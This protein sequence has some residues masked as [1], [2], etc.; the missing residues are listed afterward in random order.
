LP[1]VQ[2]FFS[3]QELSDDE[4]VQLLSHL[5]E[6]QW[7]SILDLDLWTRDQVSVERFLK[8][9]QFIIQVEDPVARKILRGT[10]PTLWQLAFK[11]DLGLFAR[12][13][14]DEFETGSE[15]G[16]FLTPEGHYLVV[17]PEDVEKARLYRQLILRLYELDGSY[18]PYLFNQTRFATSVEL[19][20][21]AYQE[22]KL[23]VED[24][25][26]QDYFDAM[27]IYTERSLL[28][29]L[30]EKRWASERKDGISLLPTRLTG[31]EGGPLLLFQV[32]AAL[33]KEEEIQHLVEELFFVCNKLL[34]A[35]QLLPSAPA[36]IKE[37]IRK[38]ISGINL[39]LELWSD[40]QLER[41][42]SGVRQR[43]LVSF[44]QIGYGRLSLL[45]R[46][47]EALIGKAPL[48]SFLEAAVEGLCLQ[49][50]VLS[51]QVGGEIQHRY[52][53]TRYD[54]K[55]ARKI[56]EEVVAQDGSR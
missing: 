14:E 46:S 37:G 1:A 49:F 42:A 9:A 55:W 10:N 29:E 20:E 41:A 30:P 5:T 45:R 6:E 39:G 53:D 21:E 11:R 18:V 17:L 32:F 3:L 25:G 50:P 4:I 19:E 56:M 51:E 27:E 40:G 31:E 48:G 8:W 22:R 28:E 7:V 38:A 23:R 16:S 52:F 34:S 15:Q 47:A 36:K 2:F 54:L 26:F 24:M 43:Y 33:S 13:E 12:T 44:F 35:D